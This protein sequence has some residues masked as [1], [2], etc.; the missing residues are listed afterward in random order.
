MTET[1]GDGAK[2]F[3]VVATIESLK[4]K[5][6]LLHTVPLKWIVQDVLYYPKDFPKTTITGLIMAGKHGR[7]PDVKKWKWYAYVIKARCSS[8]DEAERIAKGKSDV[9]SDC[10]N[11]DL[12]TLIAKQT[13][14]NARKSM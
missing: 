1:F 9:S 3:A 2:Q 13:E 6:V 8:F 10:T 4:S 12:E 5:G 11:A 7:P 14:I